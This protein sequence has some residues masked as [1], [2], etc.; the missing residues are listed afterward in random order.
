MLSS[1]YLREEERKQTEK[2]WD[3]LPEQLMFTY[4][5]QHILIFYTKY[6]FPV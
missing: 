1:Y 5:E 4:E 3:S 6:I 2:E